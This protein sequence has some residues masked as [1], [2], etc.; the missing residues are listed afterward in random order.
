RKSVGYNSKELTK[1]HKI[2]EKY[3]EFFKEKWNEYFGR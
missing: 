3:K 2:V 1:I